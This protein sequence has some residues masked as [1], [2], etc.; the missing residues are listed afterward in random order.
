MPSVCCFCFGFDAEV[1]WTTQLRPLPPFFLLFLSLQESHSALAASQ[2]DALRQR[3]AVEAQ[4]AQAARQLV[5][6]SSSVDATFAAWQ[7]DKRA[8]DSLLN[9]AAYTAAATGTAALVAIFLD[10]VYR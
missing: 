10:T 1:Q 4:V 3:Q 2:D 7:R 8:I 6:V 9:T 5:D